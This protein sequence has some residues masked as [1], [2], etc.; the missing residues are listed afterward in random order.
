MPTRAP[1]RTV[2]RPAEAA[3]APEAGAL[4]LGLEPWVLVPSA[5]PAEESFEPEESV[6]EGLAADVGILVGVVTVDIEV[7]LRPV[8]SAEVSPLM[9]VGAAVTI[10][11]ARL[12]PLLMEE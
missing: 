10:R 5:V 3:M 8:T 9:R 2:K 6:S 7:V 1:P 12:T 4:S 11:L